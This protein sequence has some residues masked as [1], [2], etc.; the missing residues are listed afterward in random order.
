MGVK[1][2]LKPSKEKILTTLFILIF[3]FNIIITPE[4]YPIQRSQCKLS[5]PPVCA[6]DVIELLLFTHYLLFLLYP[7]SVVLA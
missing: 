6:F 1:E 2:F 7:V 3:I 5:D 4:D